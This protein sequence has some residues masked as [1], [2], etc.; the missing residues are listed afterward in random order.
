MHALSVCEV[1]SALPLVRGLRQAF[2]EARIV[3]STT[4]SSGG[5]VARKLLAPY[6]DALI[7]APL[8]L[9]PV[10]PFFI[11]TIKPDLFLLVETD[12]WPH[13]LHCLAQRGIPTLLVNG[14]ISEHSFARY[15]RFAFFFR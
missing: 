1:T 9:G 14:R 10:V 3:F 2:P 12:F 7:A 8:D 6:T 5:E 4:T 11:R 15:Q 13:W